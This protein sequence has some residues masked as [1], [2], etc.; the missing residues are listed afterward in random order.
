M[1][2]KVKKGSKEAK[3]FMASLRARKK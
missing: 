2:K 3:D 1:K